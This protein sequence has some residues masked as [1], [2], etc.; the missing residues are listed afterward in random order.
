MEDDELTRARRALRGVDP[1]IDLTRVYAESWARAHDTGTHV[2]WDPDER[3]EIVL[4]GAGPDRLRTRRAVRR[5]PVLAWGAAAAAAAVA[6]V[7][8]VVSLPAPGTVPGSAPTGGVSATTDTGPTPGPRPTVGLTP[9]GVVDRAAEAVAAAGCGVKTRSSLGDQSMLRFDDGA[10]DATTDQG[11]S[12]DATTDEGTTDEAA[13]T[14][15]TD[16]LAADTG[17]P[18]V[19]PL[20]KR[21]LEVLQRTAVDTALDLSG[22]AATDYRLYP[23]LTFDQDDGAT[24]ARLRLTPPADAVPGGAVTRMD[25]LVDLTTWLP[26]TSQ[27][28]AESND[29]REFVVL[30]EF[31][32][33]TCAGPTPSSSA[34]PP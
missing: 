20:G 16:D 2:D 23:D 11:T 26:H 31:Q 19:T 7:V 12:D 21:P 15:A 30:S 6:L 25:V 22:L 8:S 9:A 24:L 5:G 13:D 10:P 3:V 4:H 28:W 17:P 14:G 32:W 27:T 18:E 33:T 29:G 1:E 34:P